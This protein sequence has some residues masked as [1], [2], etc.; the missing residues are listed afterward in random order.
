MSKKANSVPVS[1]A[2][3]ILFVSLGAYVGAVKLVAPEKHFG[4]TSVSLAKDGEDD[5]DEDKDEDEDSDDDEDKDDDKVKKEA[6][7]QRKEAEKRR[8]ESMKKEMN[9]RGAM[10]VNDDD[11]DEDEDNEEAEDDSHGSSEGMYKDKEKTLEKINKNLSRI[12]EDLLKQ[13][14][15]GVDVSV[16]LVALA[17]YKAQVGSV[18]EA[19]DAK[20]LEA[21]KVLA[22]QIKKEAHFLKK[23]AKDAEKVAKEMVD[24]ANR[25]SKAEAKLAELEALG[26]DATA[27]RAQL[28]IL[29]A[30]YATLQAT[31]A[32]APG[33]LTRETV[34]VL[35]KKVQRIKSLAERAIFALGG[36]DDGE[37]GEDH[38]DESE[39]I[40]E[41][42]MDVAEI[43][44]DDHDDVA[45]Q[46]RSMAVSQKVAAKTVKSALSDFEKR[47][48]VAEF[49]IGKDQEAAARLSA[50]V[51]AMQTRATTLETLAA[52][53]TDPEMQQILLDQ[54]KALQDQATKLSTYLQT[55]NSSFSLFG[56]LFR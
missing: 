56:W 10:S 15:E 23:D 20:N 41:H 11:L 1:V 45:S 8:T 18:G 34:K 33:T 16:Q 54:A 9:K 50:E 5:D 24:V 44:S 3:M 39:D 4:L 38:E 35:E 48:K 21:A 27:L 55:Q 29:R 14:S 30:D 6:E 51:A 32:A 52:Q 22:K 47:S 37:L 19:F 26:G 49:F 42:L 43:E 17:T 31:L 53:L 28:E 12:E 46:S 36:D 2:L 13:Q 40:A 25:I 7:K